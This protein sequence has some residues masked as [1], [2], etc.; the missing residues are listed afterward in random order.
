MEEQP[1]LTRREEARGLELA[2]R[3]PRSAPT[4]QAL[5][6]TVRARTVAAVLRNSQVPER[7]AGKRYRV[8]GTDLLEEKPAAEGQGAR[9][10]AQVGLY[11]YDQDALVVV[12]VDLRAG[13]V[14]EIEDRRGWQPPPT[15]EEIAEA[16]ELV[17][18][19]RDFAALR[20]Q[21]AE[22][23]VVGLL[24]RAS[25]LEGHPLHRHRIVLLT[26]WAGGEQATK[27][28]EAAVDLS[29]RAVVPVIDAD[30]ID[31]L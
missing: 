16:R 9:R 31:S 2:R 18:A 21:H 4:L 13:T 28:G 11:D 29:R 14:L 25:S 8:V 26:F 10:F 23:Q 20:R 7:L 24:G 1:L 3:Q 17:L 5:I 6:E 27:V 15:E 19:N 30:P 22:L 12:R